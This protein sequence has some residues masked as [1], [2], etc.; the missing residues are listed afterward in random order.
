VSV[1]LDAIVERWGDSHQSEDPFVV[2]GETML[3]PLLVQAVT[4]ID[5]LVREVER[6][7]ACVPV[8]SIDIAETPNDPNRC[9]VCGWTLSPSRD[10][11]C[12]RGD[13]SMR[14]KPETFYDADRAAEEYAAAR[15]HDCDLGDQCPRQ[16]KQR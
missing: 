8:A 6:L 3:R 11:G 12:V 2:L 15:A 13:C 9:A 5:T 1:D 16:G 10:L 4:D 7:R 14:P